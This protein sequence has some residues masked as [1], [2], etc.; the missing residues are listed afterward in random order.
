MKENISNE[1]YSEP[2]EI[3]NPK[4]SYV[5]CYRHYESY[6]EGKELNYIEEFLNEV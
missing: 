4:E 6:Y 5:K 2:E 3:Q 1:D